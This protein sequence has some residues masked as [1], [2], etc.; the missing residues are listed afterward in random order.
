[1][2]LYAAKNMWKGEDGMVSD[3]DVPFRGGFRGG[4]RGPGMRRPFVD[5]RF[6]HR[7][8]RRGFVFPFVFGPWAVPWGYPGYAPCDTYDRYGRCCDEWGRCGY[9]A[10]GDYNPVGGQMRYDWD[11]D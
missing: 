5:G 9:M 2:K 4:M 8:F 3:Y 1:M 11:D 10:D 6:P 7:G